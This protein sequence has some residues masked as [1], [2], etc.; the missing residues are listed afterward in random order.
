M[1]PANLT[2]RYRRIGRLNV[3]LYSRPTAIFLW[4]LRGRPASPPSPALSP[5]F[6]PR[7]NSVP[8]MKHRLVFPWKTL[9]LPHCLPPIREAKRRVAIIRTQ[10]YGLYSRRSPDAPAQASPSAL[11]FHSPPAPAKRL[12]RCRFSGESPTPDNFNGR[13]LCAT[14]MNF[15]AKR[16]ERYKTP[17]EAMRRKSTKIPMARTMPGTPAFTLRPIR[18]SMLTLKKVLRIFL[19]PI[20]RKTTSATS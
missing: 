16:R 19:P 1:C 17:L 2:S 18:L 14:G 3:P 5:S 15:A 20:I 13:S 10:P 12:S 4:S 7:R 9:P 6:R 8:G 11:C